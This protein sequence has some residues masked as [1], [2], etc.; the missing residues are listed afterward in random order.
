[1]GACPE[2]LLLLRAGLAPVPAM[3]GGRA[4]LPP[5]SCFV[6]LHYVFVG[7]R[8]VRVARWWCLRE[9]MGGISMVGRIYKATSIRLSKVPGESGAPPPAPAAVAGAP[10]CSWLPA[11][12]LSLS[13]AM[14]FL[15]SILCTDHTS[16][17]SGISS[18]HHS[19]LHT[20][21]LLPSICPAID[22]SLS[23]P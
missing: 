22:Y 6:V 23:C 11:L 3:H 5:P 15:V 7:A 8:R 18:C 9:K 19:S 10:V 12:S 17:Q 20:H 2:R 13:T 21:T 1:M 16:P 14:G 4:A